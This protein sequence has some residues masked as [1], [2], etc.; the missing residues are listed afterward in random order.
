[1]PL[2]F[3][4]TTVQDENYMHGFVESLRVRWAAFGAS[5][6]TVRDVRAEKAEYVVLPKVGSGGP[7]PR[8]GSNWW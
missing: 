6:Q 4:S 8:K 5:G 3:T 2:L 1:M 7:T